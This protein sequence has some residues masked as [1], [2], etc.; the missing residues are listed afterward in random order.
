MPPYPTRP[1]LTPFPLPDNQPWWTFGDVEI[2]DDTKYGGVDL[3][4][5]QLV[6][7]CLGTNFPNTRFTPFLFP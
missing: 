5:R 1:R 3:E 4:L 2:L 6:F 7:R